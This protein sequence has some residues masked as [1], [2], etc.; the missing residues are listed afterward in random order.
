MG[1]LDQGRVLV[2]FVFSAYSWPLFGHSMVRRGW[3]QLDVP[4]RWPLASAKV[5]E[6]SGSG[7]GRWRRVAQPGGLPQPAG[8]RRVN[9][10]EA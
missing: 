10:D 3:R 1:I 7:G 8:S 6:T 2:L 9:P 4:T 5:Q